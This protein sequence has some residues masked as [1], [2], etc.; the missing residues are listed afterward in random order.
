MWASQ[1]LYVAGMRGY[2]ATHEWTDKLAGTGPAP[3]LLAVRCYIHC[4]T[5]LVCPTS[6]LLNLYI[7]FLV[8]LGR[9]LGREPLTCIRVRAVLPHSKVLSGELRGQSPHRGVVRILTTWRDRV[10][11]LGIRLGPG[12]KMRAEWVYSGS[13]R[14]VWRRRPSSAWM[15][16]AATVSCESVGA[17]RGTS[18]FVCLI[19]LNMPVSI[20]PGSTR[21]VLISGV[22]YL[23]C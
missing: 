23:G 7:L 13:R 22:S 20:W 11:N 9:P 14:V 12:P 17:M 10:M 8:G 19:W 16:A 5:C 2:L 1:L 3:L 6:A 4:G 15:M 21:V 18:G